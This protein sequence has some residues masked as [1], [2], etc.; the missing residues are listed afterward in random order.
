MGEERWVCVLVLLRMLFVS[1]M[2]LGEKQWV[3]IGLDLFGG[4]SSIHS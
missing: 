4:N 1:G 2:A 3:S